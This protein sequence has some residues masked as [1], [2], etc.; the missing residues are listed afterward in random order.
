MQEEHSYRDPDLTLR[1]LS[2]I[3]NISTH[4]ISETLRDEI[5]QNFYDFVNSCRIAEACNLLKTTDMGTIDIAFAVGF[6]S[7]STFSAAFKKHQKT[8][9]STYRKSDNFGALPNNQEPH[10][11][12]QKKIQNL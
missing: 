10:Q 2:D 12:S 4:H 5:G 11:T 6:N 9:P 1:K 8:S 3:L 7:R